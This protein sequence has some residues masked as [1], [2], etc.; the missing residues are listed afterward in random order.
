MLQADPNYRISAKEALQHPW[1]AKL[2]QL[3]YQLKVGNPNGLFGEVM[4]SM[5]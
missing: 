1:L 3:H 4:C 5:M 2:K